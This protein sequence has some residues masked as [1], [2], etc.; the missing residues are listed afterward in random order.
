M[1]LLRQLIIVIATLFILMFAGSTVIN[2]HNTR[3]YLNNQLRSISQDTATSLGLSL[4][5]HMAKGEMAIIESKINAV[6]D[7][8]YYREVVLVDVND[9][10]VIERIQ[11]LVIKG[12]PAWFVSWVSLDT[13]RGEANIMA[14]WKQSGKIRISANPGYAYATL[15]GNSM[16]SFWW[17]LGFSGLALLLGVIALRYILQPLRAVEEQAKAICNREFP[18]QDQIPWTLELRNVVTAMNLMSSKIKDI[19]KEQA[20]AL[21]RLRAD[22][23]VDS[24]TGLAN[25]LYFDMQLSQLTK[26]R[27]SSSTSALVFIELDEFKKFNERRG[28]QAGDELLRGC[29]KLIEETCQETPNLDY[30]VSRLGG[31]NFAVVIRN[32]VDEGAFAF[33]EKL[34]QS[35]NKLQERGLADTSNVGHIGVSIHRGQSA[36]QLLSEADMALRTAQIK[37]HNAVHISDNK[38]DDDACSYPAS[39]WM[40]VLSDVLTE[41]RIVLHRQPCVSCKDDTQVLHYETLLRIF[42]HEG[43]LIPA[44]VVIPMA[45]HLHLTQDFDKHVVAE[46]LARLG[47]PENADV[48]MAVNLFPMSIQ[49]SGFV[50]WLCDILLKH[51]NVAPRIALELM[52]HG[53]TDNLDALRSWVERIAA[54]GAKTGLDQVGKGF[55]SFN[56]LS[57]LK[58]DYIK[59]DGSY[60]RG[61]QIN[62][63]NQFFVDSLVK[64]AHGLGIQVIAESLETREEWD[65]FKGLRVDGVKGYGVGQPTK[66]E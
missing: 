32:V 57:T 23:Y 56:Y 37:G 6:S 11:P 38:T 51:A 7:S 59:I 60:A 45:K 44:T 35:L 46:T 33:A 15:W 55:K 36:G 42:D 9:K 53:A 2:I 18:V 41:C 22:S 4:S 26:K 20:D 17:F 54:T 34:G 3:S 48:V 25:R 47:R 8:G 24:V 65:T 61:I 10:A 28:Y 12:V 27:I 21:E 43:V 16:A 64:F 30:F 66:W 52:E 5:P 14:G 62:K 63:D 19:F 13:P 1:T 29:G 39:H 49:D 40:K 31:A 50:A 58:L